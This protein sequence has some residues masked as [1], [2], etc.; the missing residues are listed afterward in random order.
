[1]EN[2]LLWYVVNTLESITIVSTE[3]NLSKMLAVIQT[4][5]KIAKSYESEEQ[6]VKKDG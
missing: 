3:D 6:E 5:K 4:I 2:E 1:M